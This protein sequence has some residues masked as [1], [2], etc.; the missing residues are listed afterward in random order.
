VKSRVIL[1]TGTSSGIGYA[2]AHH[3]TSQGDQVFGVSRKNPVKSFAWTQI[4]ADLTIEEDISQLFDTIKKNTDTIDIL[5][6]CAGMGYAGALEETSLKEMTYL[7]HV[8]V[9]APLSM[10]NHA[11]PFLRNSKDA[12]IVNIGSV[13]SEITIPFQTLYSMSKS[14]LYRLTEGLRMELKPEHIQVTTVLPGDTKTEFTNNRTLLLNEKS[15]YYK[16]AKNSIDKMAKDEEK[17]MPVDAVVK[18]VA[19]QLSKKNMKVYVSVGVQYKLFVLLVHL[20]PSKLREYII[21]K[22]YAS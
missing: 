14:A 1:I 19:K 5:I 17:G 4:N 12:R 2:L 13:A 9:F 20:L 7:F 10:I 15:H 18:T 16:R 11:L 3:F 8:N 22:M 6:N 21:Y